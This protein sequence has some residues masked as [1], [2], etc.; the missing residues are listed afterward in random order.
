ML[1]AYAA[2]AEDTAEVDVEPIKR[3]MNENEVPPAMNLGFAVQP[4]PPE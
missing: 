2:W 4:T 3:L 1:R